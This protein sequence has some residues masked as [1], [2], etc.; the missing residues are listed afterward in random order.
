MRAADTSVARPCTDR[1]HL[2]RELAFALR[3]S[4]EH[5]S[6]S[7]APRLLRV[8][9]SSVDAFAR[10][11]HT[12]I[13][14][15]G[16]FVETRDSFELRA[17]V[18]VE[19]DLTFLQE[20]IT[21]EGE[22]V[23]S[24]PAEL[25]ASGAVPGAAVHFDWPVAQL[26]ELLEPRASGAKPV[27]DE[28]AQSERRRAPRAP[29]KGDT[30]I[31]AGDA[32]FSGRMRDLSS[33]GAL[34]SVS[35]S[36]PALGTAVRL[37]IRNP[38]SGDEMCVAGAVARHLTTEAGEVSAVGIN[39]APSEEGREEVERFLQG[40]QSAEHTRRLGG[41]SGALSEV[42]VSDL[43]QMLG[44]IAPCGTLTLSR[45]TEEGVIAF[46]NGNLCEARLGAAAGVKALSRMLEWS[47]GS[48]EFH[49]R[50]DDDETE[51]PSL[52]LDVAIRDAT[53]QVDE[54]AQL[55][56]AAFPP[57]AMVRRAPGGESEGAKTR[58]TTEEAVLEL[59]EAG[60]RVAAIL[61][62]V[63][64]RDAEIFEALVFLQAEGAITVE[65]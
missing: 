54:V 29:A 40:V 61:D 31:D 17:V 3:H 63:P 19:L 57:H 42:E 56:T 11:Y 52:P 27:E 24:V 46:R 47:E 26:R 5:V 15:G 32:S 50:V 58:S 49:A 48:F 64:D 4:G 21:L 37:T 51:D 1:E 14:K 38:K 43:L 28:P 59:A 35:G 8:S 34:I 62:V 13:A 45:G 39:F 9:Y 22:V 10:E 25:A 36:A 33:V 2:W 60:F 44:R 53:F 20:K 6:R 30:R 23:H 12:N 65:T 18:R 41:L 55:D 7:G 16:I